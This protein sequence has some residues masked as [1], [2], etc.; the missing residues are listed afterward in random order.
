MPGCTNFHSAESGVAGIFAPATWE[1]GSSSDIAMVP[2]GSKDTGWL[3]TSV[4]ARPLRLLDRGFNLAS[5][6]SRS[7]VSAVVA[8]TSVGAVVVVTNVG[9]EARARVIALVRV[10]R[11]LFCVLGR[12]AFL[13]AG[14]AF[15]HA[16]ST[17]STFIYAL[18]VAYSTRQWRTTPKRG[19]FLA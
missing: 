8:S 10:I 3:R 1:V 14:T 17:C 18:E 9:A 4:F 11:E 7:V 6:I 16:S 15:H 12:A 13:E 19:F 5:A 2:L